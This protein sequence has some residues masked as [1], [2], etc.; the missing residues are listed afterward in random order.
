MDNFRNTFRSPIGEHQMNNPDCA[1]KFN[2]NFSLVLNMLHSSFLLKVL[3]IVHIL[4]GRTSLF[5]QDMPA[6]T[7]YYFGI[8]SNIIVFFPISS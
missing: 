2:V 1:E 7:E 6:K 4:F 3:E 5:K 8:V